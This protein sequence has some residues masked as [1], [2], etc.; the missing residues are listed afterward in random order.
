MESS[1]RFGLEYSIDSCM[2]HHRL[3]GSL[4]PDAR[5]DPADIIA[6]SWPRLHPR[7]DS[8]IRCQSSPTHQLYKLT[9]LEGL[10]PIQNKTIQV[11]Q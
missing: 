7:L 8:D 5:W 1:A 2:F 10:L 4:R 3:T 11:Q 9:W 6:S